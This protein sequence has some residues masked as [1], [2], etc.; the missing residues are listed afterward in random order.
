LCGKPNAT[1][2]IKHQAGVER[3]MDAR[4][5]FLNRVRE[6]NLD[7]GNFLGLLHVLIGRR[8]ET[9]ENQLISSG[10]TWR[11]LAALL[12]KIRWPKESV[13]ELNLNPDDLPMRDRERF[14]YVAIAHARVDSPDAH[15]AGDA[16]AAILTK[17]GYIVGPAPGTKKEA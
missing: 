14:W 17:A 12:K 2:A 8:L 16:F 15:K 3:R 13:T 6:Q 10:I 1:V 11:D 4:V 5:D 7:R 9:T